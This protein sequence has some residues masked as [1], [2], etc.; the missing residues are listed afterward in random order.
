M[1][2]VKGLEEK[3]HVEWLRVLGFF[4]LEKRRLRGDLIMVFNIFVRGRGGAGTDLLSLVTSGRI[5]GNVMKLC[6]KRF[7]SDI[8]KKVFHSEGG[9]AL[10]QAPQGSG[11]S[12]KHDR[13]QELFGQCSQA[14]GVL[15]GNGPVQ[16]QELDFDD[17]CESLPAMIFY[18]SIN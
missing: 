11:L 3:L 10:E 12:T 9:W 8:R 16:D 5:Q 1:K 13:V 17:P 14:H 15:L 4:S 2:M 6:Q 18:D 7:R